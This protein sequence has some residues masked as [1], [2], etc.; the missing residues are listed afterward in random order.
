MCSSDLVQ[1]K[2]YSLA[3]PAPNAT[4]TMAEWASLLRGYFGS[5]MKLG[6]AIVAS[7]HTLLKRHV[8][9]VP[10][11]KLR[12]LDPEG[13]RRLMRKKVRR[14]G[15]VTAGGIPIAKNVPQLTRSTSYDTAENRHIKF[16]L[17][18]LSFR[19]QQIARTSQS[20]DEDADQTAEVRFFQYFQPIAREMLRDVQRLLQNTFLS[21]IRS[22]PLFGGSS[23]VLQKHRT[24]SAFIR[25]ARL[26]SGGLSLTSGVLTIGLKH[27]A[28][29]Y[30]Y[31][32]FLKLVS[33]LHLRFE[34]TQ[35]SFVKLRNTRVV[36]VLQ[37]GQSAAVTF[38]SST[39]K[40]IQVVYNRRFSDL[41]TLAQKPDNV[42]QL[43][44]ARSLH[45]LDAKYRIAAD[46]K[47]LKLF[48]APGPVPDDVNTMHRY[49]DAIVLPKLVGGA[50]YERG[51]VKDAIVLFPYHD[52]QE[53]REHKLYRSIREV[54]VGG[55]PLLPN[56]TLLLEQHLAQLLE[57]DGVI[58]R[59]DGQTRS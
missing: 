53:F 1:A 16:V 5:L 30:E 19:L 18:S 57:A 3:A 37:K 28:E 49:R 56:S 38:S 33:L 32:C 27:I 35:T 40:R 12:R 21:G 47:Y 39:G 59:E 29:L 7:P 6:N 34:L 55:I 10:L 45:I 14:T 4:P 20:G 44:T 58:A 54:R 42:I 23:Q 48:G 13:F 26:L 46:Q 24:Y 50:G 22:E 8:G 2:T 43:T 51:V 52:E 25:T 36:I 9:Q 15:G 41:P 31:W 11:E 17:S